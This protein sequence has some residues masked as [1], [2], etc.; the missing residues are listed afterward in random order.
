MPPSPPAG[1]APSAGARP[2]SRP[3]SHAATSA[4]AATL[5]EAY[6][7]F[8]PLIAMVGMQMLAQSIIHATL[9]RQAG[10]EAALAAY[11]LGF[12]LHN[13]LGSPMWAVQYL[14]L[15]TI[16][17]RPSV[18]R[19]LLFNLKLLLPITVVDWLVAFTP[20]GDVLFGTLLGASPAVARE[21]RWVTFLFYWEMPAF[22]L[23]SVGV[24]ILM[25]NQRTPLI[26][27]GSATRLLAVIAV[28]ALLRPWV[29][30]GALGALA[31]SLAIAA[32]SAIMLLV[33]W[34]FYRALPA[35][36]APPLSDRGLW[37]FDWPLVLNRLAENGMPF[38]V[39]VFLGR[40]ARPVLAIASFGV[41]NGL[42]RLILSPLINLSHA[43]QTLVRTRED[44]RTMVRF[45]WQIVAWFSAVLLALFY[46]PLR[47][48]VLDRVMGLPPEMSAQVAPALLL[49]LATCVCWAFSTLFRGMLAAAHHTRPIATGSLARIAAGIA[50]GLGSLA[51][52]GANGAVVGLLMLT[53]SFAAEA[54][55]MGW[56]LL[57]PHPALPRKGG[58]RTA[59]EPAGAP[60]GEPRPPT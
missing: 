50:V 41:L 36:G 57:T 54:L 44:R 59:A 38:L 24:A 15:A 33:A 55:V 16:R 8:V 13:P 39:N 14:A 18:R 35:G 27:L 22:M 52:A 43:A 17:D 58:G 47:A 10:A 2:A 20:A 53:V 60:A 49:T 51:V 34:R 48:V 4:H 1:A 23:R 32:D 26:T 56:A 3:A 21:A 29:S 28:L 5:G 40:L 45:T 37:A 19:L 7:F 12:S 9:A 31:Y 42:V 46:T 30:G 6:R 11:A 25:L